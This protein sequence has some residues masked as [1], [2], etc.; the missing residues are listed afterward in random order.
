MMSTYNRRN[1]H[2][3]TFHLKEDLN[4]QTD[5]LTITFNASDVRDGAWRSFAFPPISDSAGRS[6]YF[7]L[8]SPESEPG[9]AVSVMGRNDDRYPWGQGFING[10]PT[11]GD[12]TFRIFYRMSLEQ[13][14]NWVLESL[15]A[16]KPSVWG[17]ENFYVLLAVLYALLLGALLWQASDVNQ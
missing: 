4:A 16:N 11:P 9:N 13:K 12:M 8:E 15:A 7:Y 17:N 10:H 3:V 1:T 5:I 2:D 6:F 14:I